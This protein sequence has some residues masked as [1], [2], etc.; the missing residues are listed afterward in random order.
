MY[1]TIII[2]NNNNNNQIVAT[3][4]SLPRINI[5]IAINVAALT[6]M[7]TCVLIKNN[8]EDDTNIEATVQLINDICD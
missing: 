7:S 2:Y 6:T 8:D 5:A 1:V 3:N 4:L